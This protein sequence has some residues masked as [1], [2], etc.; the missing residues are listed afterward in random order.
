M[1]KAIG[2]LLMGFAITGLITGCNA[3]HPTNQATI[4]ETA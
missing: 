3:N 1:K 2:L 4:Q